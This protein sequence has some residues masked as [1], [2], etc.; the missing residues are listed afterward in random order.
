M[1][2]LDKTWVKA[3]SSHLKAKSEFIL[4]QEK[5]K[6]TVKR[7]LLLSLKDTFDKHVLIIPNRYTQLFEDLL[8]FS[9][10]GPVSRYV[11]AL[12]LAVQRAIKN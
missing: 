11:L 1:G 9:Y 8:E 7:E 2:K 10:N 12:A 4:S 3:V 6:D 5:L